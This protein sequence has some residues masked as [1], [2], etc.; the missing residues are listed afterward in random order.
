MSLSDENAGISVHVCDDTESLDCEAICLFLSK[1]LCE[2]SVP[3]PCEL[4]VLVVDTGRMEDMN[5]R[6]MGKRGSTD[7]ISLPV[8]VPEDFEIEAVSPGGLMLGD[9]IICP[10][11]IF[12]KGGDYYQL[13]NKHLINYALAHA[14]LHIMGYE[15]SNEEDAAQMD[16]RSIEL[17]EKIFGQVIESD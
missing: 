3:L 12:E 16:K 9:I 10:D 5:L 1:A 6:L 15:D 14:L 8:S 11:F 7:V 13:P 4:S 2:L 17:I